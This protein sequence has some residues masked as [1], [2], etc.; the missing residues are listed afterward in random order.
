MSQNYISTPEDE[1]NERMR[2]EMI[3]HR[4][5]QAVN[6]YLQLQAL[7]HRCRVDYGLAKFFNHTKEV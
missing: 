1:R 6:D 3:Q 5:R 4:N 2:L 7:Q